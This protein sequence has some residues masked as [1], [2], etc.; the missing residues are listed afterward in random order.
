M[1]FAMMRLNKPSA[2]IL[3]IFSHRIKTSKGGQVVDQLVQHQLRSLILK[4][5][6]STGQRII[7]E[8]NGR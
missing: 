1:I 7:S 5:T 2:I 3:Y 4:N 6:T 8:D